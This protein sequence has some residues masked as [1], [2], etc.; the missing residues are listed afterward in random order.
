MM[1][2]YF[3]VLFQSAQNRFQR[4]DVDGEDII[5]ALELFTKHPGKKLVF[6]QKNTAKKKANISKRRKQENRRKEDHPKCA[7]IYDD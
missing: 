4:E 5:V 6:K 7:N 2:I 3:H 1:M